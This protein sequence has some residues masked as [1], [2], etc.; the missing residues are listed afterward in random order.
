MIY[1]IPVTTY[2]KMRKLQI[3][4]PMLAAAIEEN[5]VKFVA[6]SPMNRRK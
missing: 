1:I 2:L 3:M 6:P 4:Y 5:E